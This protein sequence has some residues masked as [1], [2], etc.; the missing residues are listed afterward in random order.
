MPIDPEVL[1][2]LTVHR[3]DRETKQELYAHEEC[4]E[5]ALLDPKMLYLKHL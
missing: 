2:T 4:L 1:Y 3:E 5:Q